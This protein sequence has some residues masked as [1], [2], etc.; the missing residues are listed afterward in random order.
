MSAGRAAAATRT[1]TRPRPAPARHQSV[2]RALHV[3]PRPSIRT[4]RTPFV[5]L[6]VGVLASGL[7]GLL[8]LNTA[9]AQG[10]FRLHDL[11]RQSAQ[12]SD[13]QQA[14][15]LTIDA[16]G[17][18]HHL[19]RKAKRLGLVPAHDPGFLRLADGKVLG[20]PSAATLPPPPPP[21]DQQTSTA[22]GTAKPDNKPDAKTQTRAGAKPGTKPGTTANPAHHGGHR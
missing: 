19:A 2:R 3:V 1:A 10:S 5:L 15:Q 18:P 11:S 16:A 9:L 8:L 21:P 14:L 7:I 4:P 13:R 20:D 22:D 17:T 6:V 12:L